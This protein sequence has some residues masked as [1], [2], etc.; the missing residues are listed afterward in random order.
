MKLR[1]YQDETVDAIFGFL[2]SREGN[3]CAVLPT[4]AGKSLVLAELCREVAGWGCR[5]LVLAHVK[6]LLEQNAAKIRALAP[7]LGVGIFSAGLGQKDL[8]Y[9]VTVAGI[10]S[11]YQ[12]A[13]AL[14]TINLVIV[15]EAHLIPPEG[16]GMYR[17]L[18][19]D[20]LRINPK[21]RVVGLTATPYRTKAGSI[22]GPDNILTHVCHEVSVTDLI[23]QGYLSRLRAKSGTDIAD[24]SGVA[25]R[26]GEY[27]AG[28][29]QKAMDTDFLVESA[30]AEIVRLTEDRRSVLIFSAG[31]DHGLHI[32]RTLDEKHGVTCGF[33]DGKTS[34]ADRDATLKRFQAG[35][36]KYLCNVN[37]LTT[38]FDAPNIDCIA[39]L[40]STLS[41]GL[42]YQMVGRGFRIAEGKEDCLILD[43]GGNVLRHGPVDAIR[44]GSAPKGGGGSP[45]IRECPECNEIVGISV[46][47]CPCCGHTFEVADEEAKAT[48]APTAGTEAPVSQGAERIESRV[49]ETRYHIHTKRN[50]EDA[51]KTLRVEYRLGL[52]D[53]VSEWVCFSHEGFARRK[54]EQWWAKRSTEPVPATT[55]DAYELAQAG[56]LAKTKSIVVQKEPGKFD[57]IVDHELGPVPGRLDA[58]DGISDEVYARYQLAQL[59]I[60]ESEIPF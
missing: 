29:A 51:P 57:K 60:D 34:D 9:T 33:V 48:H 4:G 18:L 32:V 17:Y 44:L 14:G 31:V 53:T 15:D 5:V 26:G 52:V 58:P 43:Y 21:M 28:E 19:K 42:Y 54:A 6:E 55:E 37:V 49:I 27:V 59:D 35:D 16:D 24:M 45:P 8:G 13:A 50:N 36:L 25:V 47:A 56:S 39:L 41:P 11:V 22:C 23:A 10:Q 7:D 12:L 30:C 3:P 46:K 38:G 40:R 1:P 2:R 20:L